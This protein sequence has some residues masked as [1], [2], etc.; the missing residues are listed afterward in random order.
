MN[1]HYFW[2]SEGD[3]RLARLTLM[4]EMRTKLAKPEQPMTTSSDSGPNHGT[5]GFLF[6]VIRD[7]LLLLRRQ[8]VLPVVTV[9]FALHN[10]DLVVAE[11]PRLVKDGL[12]GVG[13]HAVV[14]NL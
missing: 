13:R 4:A 12:R 3:V 7:R 2:Y 5:S 1:T 6:T 8:N 9:V 10:V 14:E 11:V